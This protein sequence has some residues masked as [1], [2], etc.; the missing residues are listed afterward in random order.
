[1]KIKQVQAFAVRL[2]RDLNAVTGTAGIPARL[3]GE[4]QYRPAEHFR[5]VYSSQIETTLVRVVT[6]TSLIGWGEAQ[7]PV[8]PEISAATIDTLLGP[9]IIGK[10]A[11]APE[12]LWDLM[13]T[14]M[15][16]R[17]H[18]GGFY[19]DAIAGID[20]AIWDLC[21]K[22]LGQPVYRLLGGPCRCA[23]P[24]YVSGLAGATEEDR[25]ASFRDLHEQGNK[26][27]KLFVDASPE[28]CLSLISLLRADSPAGG[29]CQRL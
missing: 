20:I 19:L 4:S 5:T 26:A 11:L 24:Y 13:Y 2:P 8:A 17:G 10:D 3:V 14:A 29:A 1:M 7:S 28:E 15:R 22:A 25:L 27:Y 23:V 6:D 12:H 16:V 18:T 21:G 9:M